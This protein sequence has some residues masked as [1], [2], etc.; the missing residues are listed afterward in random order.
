MCNVLILFAEG[1][2][3][4]AGSMSD[5]P[6]TNCKKSGHSL[7][8]NQFHMFYQGMALKLEMTRSH[9]RDHICCG[10]T[11]AGCQLSLSSSAGQG[12]DCI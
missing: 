8:G 4:F 3:V 5:T 12:R 7:G 11:V 2:E 6:D 10:L 9:F 1:P